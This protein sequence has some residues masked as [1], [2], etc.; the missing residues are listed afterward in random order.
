MAAVNPYEEYQ[1]QS[2]MTMTQGELV[3]HHTGAGNRNGGR[4]GQVSAPVD[5]DVIHCTI[6]V[7]IDGVE[8]LADVG[9]GRAEIA[10]LD[11]GVG[12]ENNQGIVAEHGKVGA[13]HDNLVIGPAVVVLSLIHI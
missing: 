12:L 5:L 13:V 11:A 1:K 6:P 8:R 2:I 4:H 7:L 10:H 9:G 3:V